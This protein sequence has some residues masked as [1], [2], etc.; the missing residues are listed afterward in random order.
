M[1]PLAVRQR[2]HH[3]ADSPPNC[4][5]RQPHRYGMLTNRFV[6]SVAF[7]QRCEAKLTNIVKWL[8]NQLSAVMDLMI[9]TYDEYVDPVVKKEN[10]TNGTTSTNGTNGHSTNGAN[11]TNGAEASPKDVDLGSTQHYKDQVHEMMEIVRDQRVKLAREVERWC[12]E[13]GV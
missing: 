2:I 13:R 8:P 7:P 10:G 12:A 9:S 6:L 3:Q 4:N 11:G 1:A 5:R